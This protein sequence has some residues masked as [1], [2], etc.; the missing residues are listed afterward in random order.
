M[1]I[2]GVEVGGTL[3]PPE[4]IPTDRYIPPH[5]P[6]VPPVDEG[7]LKVGELVGSFDGYFSAGNMK[8]NGD[9]S[10]TIGVPYTDKYKAMPISD[11]R[12]TIFTIVVYEKAWDDEEPIGPEDVDNEAIEQ[13]GIVTVIGGRSPHASPDTAH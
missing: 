8:S 11:M 9:M 6:E 12:Q 10:I 2:D 1:I 3:T 13:D 4:P 7:G 5:R